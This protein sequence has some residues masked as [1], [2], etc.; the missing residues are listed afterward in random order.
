MKEVNENIKKLIEANKLTYFFVVNRK[1]RLNSDKQI[2]NDEIQLVNFQGEI[3]FSQACD[4]IADKFIMKYNKYTK[5]TEEDYT[6]AANIMMPIKKTT[7]RNRKTNYRES[8]YII[9][10]G[11]SVNK[12]WKLGKHYTLHHMIHYSSY[13]NENTPVYKGK[14]KRGSSGGCIVLPKHEPGDILDFVERN[15]INVTQLIINEDF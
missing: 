2:F 8:A 10:S 5:P 9:L 4:S 14:T 7:Y 1:S 12:K 13:Y 6:I 11:Y 3:L 15:K